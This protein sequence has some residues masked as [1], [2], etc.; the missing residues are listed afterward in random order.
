MK[1]E[2][3]WII[4]L[5]TVC[6]AKYCLYKQYRHVYSLW[7]LHVDLQNKPNIF[8]QFFTLREVKWLA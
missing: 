3:P 5:N 7:K 1:A 6:L 8:I 4:G 2:E